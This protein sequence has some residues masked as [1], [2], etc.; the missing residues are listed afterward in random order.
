MFAERPII[1]V[2]LAFAAGCVLAMWTS[3]APF[4][5]MA[6]CG[7]G[8]AA[9]LYSLACGQRSWTVLLTAVALLGVARA[10]MVQ[11][12]G[13]WDISRLAGRRG[14]VVLEGYICSDP[15]IR[16][17]RVHV[18]VRVTDIVSARHDTPVTGTI[19][20]NLAR[21]AAVVLLRTHGDSLEYGQTLRFGGR[22]T[23]PPTGRNPGEFSFERYL[24]RQGVFCEM[25][26]DDPGSL[27]L[28]DA[29]G[30]SGAMRWAAAA[31]KALCGLFGNRLP[32][33]EAGLVSGMLLGSYTL[34]P[35]DLIENFTRSGTLH[36]LAASGFN[37]ALIVTIFWHGLL[38]RMKAP[39]IP[40]LALVIGLVGFYVL[41]VG[42]K[43]SIVRAGVG[44]SLFL[45]A[46]ILGRPAS[47]LAVLFGTAFLILL[48][49]P[50]AIADIGFQLSFAAVASIIAIVPP[51]HAWSAV[52]STPGQRLTPAGR[53]LRHLMDVAVVTSAATIATL[54]IIAH[55]FSRLSLV[56]LPANMAVAALAEW[57]FVASVALSFLFWIPGLDWALTQVV[58]GLAAAV[59][60][61]VN[62]IGGLAFAQVNIPSPGV[63]WIAI[64]YAAMAAAV[65][66]LRAALARAK[67]PAPFP[68]PGTPR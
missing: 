40:A 34:V 12:P 3:V 11:T 1:P 18:M 56:S 50:L 51:F 22:V 43:P 20:L 21:E 38:R 44:A 65:V 8:C 13:P 10:A 60:W 30:G 57:L 61:V 39:R 5:G 9:A 29:P 32:E 64:Y 37:C 28:L 48:F 35:A 15:A 24:A 54:P 55:Y 36:L 53:L 16:P 17:G 19:S 66:R 2:T 26:T 47:M 58:Y 7:I 67:E 41:M 59:A 68:A 42:A 23:R 52:R 45:G 46:L 6:A 25:W 33:Q 63:V 14:P 27:M 62:T 49:K 4:A 31:G